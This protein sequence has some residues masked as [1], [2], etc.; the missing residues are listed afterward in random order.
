[1]RLKTGALLPERPT[2]V[3]WLAFVAVGLIGLTVAAGPFASG[4]TKLLP[5]F[6]GCIGA[7]AAGYGFVGA[8]VDARALDE[9]EASR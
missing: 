8:Y 3:S 4:T 2:P 5:L 6:V 9:L 7:F 1:M